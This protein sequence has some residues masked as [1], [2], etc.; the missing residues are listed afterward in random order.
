MAGHR[1]CIISSCVI[2][3]FVAL[4][5]VFVCIRRSKHTDTNIGITRGYNILV[6][7]EFMKCYE[8]LFASSILEFAKSACIYPKSKLSFAIVKMTERGQTVLTLKIDLTIY[9]DVSSKKNS[10]YII[11][12]IHNSL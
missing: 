2:M 7:K 3:V 4:F 6:N 1:P 5:G 8:E 9:M 11:Y 10:I 12:Y